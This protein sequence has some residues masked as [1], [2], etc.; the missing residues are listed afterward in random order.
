MTE[1]EELL[2]VKLPTDIEVDGHDAGSEEMNI[3]I[4][5]NDPLYSFQKVRMILEKSEAWPHIRAAYRKVSGG[6]YTILWPE[7]LMDF[8]VG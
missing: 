7:G 6:N 1:T 3:F 5:T 4:L 8:R 2:A